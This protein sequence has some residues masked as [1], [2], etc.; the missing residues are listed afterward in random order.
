MQLRCNAVKGDS[1][2]L[3]CWNEKG[4]GGS[5]FIG[6]LPDPAGREPAPTAARND[7]RDHANIVAVR[8]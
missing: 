5:C 7:H 8:L 1:I 4:L 3:V 6:S 2:L